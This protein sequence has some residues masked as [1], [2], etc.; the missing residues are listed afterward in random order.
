MCWA[1]G[2]EDWSWE[3]LPYGLLLYRVLFQGTC[4]CFFFT[5][6]KVHGSTLR[7]TNTYCTLLYYYSEELMCYCTNMYLLMVDKV[8]SGPFKPLWQALILLKM[9][10]LHIFFL[11]FIDFVKPMFTQH[12]CKPTHVFVFLLVL[13]LLRPNFLTVKAHLHQMKCRRSFV[14]DIQ[15]AF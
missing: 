15:M 4:C 7:G 10:Y 1:V 13:H 12:L 9:Q 14:N 5:S 2:H 11:Y 6:K 8:Q 3:P